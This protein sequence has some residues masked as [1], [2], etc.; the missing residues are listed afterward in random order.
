MRAAI[1][2]HCHTNQSDGSLSAEDVIHLAK[3]EGIT[4][5]AITD[6]DTTKGLKEAVETGS[7][8]GVEIVPGIEISAFDYKRNRRMHILGFFVGPGHQALEKFCAP[9]TEQR[10]DASCQAVKR[11]VEAGYDI[12]W[13]QVEKY[14]EGGTGV[15]KQ[16][17]MH[18]LMDRGYCDGIYCSLYKKLFSRGNGNE[19]GIAYI[20][21][22][23]A[24][25]LAAIRA[26]RSAGGIAVLAHPGQLG[27]FEAV[28]E[29]AA[30]GLQGI[31]VFHPSHHKDDVLQSLAFAS[32]Y[33]LAVTGGSDFH[34]F[35]GETVQ[36]P[37]CTELGV[38]AVHKLKAASCK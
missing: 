31:E 37:G 12:T 38:N 33:R 20:E 8:L 28:P 22:E 17:I 14:A 35:Y 19:K 6:H 7:R 32:R 27:N 24:D 10:H 4:H 5:L 23:Y 15:Y 11:I 1:D 16:H 29:L 30:S 3:Q 13:E 25:A 18:A 2:L 26:V 34:G 21:I 9:L 36:N